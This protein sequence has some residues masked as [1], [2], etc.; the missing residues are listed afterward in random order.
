MIIKSDLF[1]GNMHARLMTVESPGIKSNSAGG[2]ETTEVVP[3]G[4]EQ[5]LDGV[6]TSRDIE[7]KH[8]DTRVRLVRCLCGL[9]LRG[10]GSANWV[11]FLE[12]DARRGVQNLHL[13]RLASELEGR[14][15][16]I[17]SDR[18]IGVHTPRNGGL[19]VCDFVLEQDL[20]SAINEADTSLDVPGKA[21]SPVNS[22]FGSMHVHSV[23]RG[24]V[25]HKV[26]G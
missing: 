17:D 2:G 25:S 15:G 16:T 22:G 23:C 24:K 10:V 18:S 7:R 9:E 20:A 4:I 14:I 3:L 6:G 26:S 1:G 13:K 12:N 5:D 8:R 11:E 21:I 19:N